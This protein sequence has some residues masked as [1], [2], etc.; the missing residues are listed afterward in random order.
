M[1]QRWSAVSVSLLL[2]SPCVPSRAKLTPSRVVSLFSRGIKLSAFG[3]LCLFLSPSAFAASVTLSWDADTTAPDLAGYML[4]YGYASR[5]YS[6]SVDV[7]NYTTF[8]H[9]GLEEGKTYYFA[10]TTY[11]VYL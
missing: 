7:G 2:V 11:D 10:A 9:S 3:L 6:V 5:N 4:Y 8:A 1:K